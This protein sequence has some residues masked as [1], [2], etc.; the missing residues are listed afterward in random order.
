MQ[1]NGNGSIFNYVPDEVNDF[2]GVFHAQRR[3]YVF[4]SHVRCYIRESV[5]IPGRNIISVKD[6]G[7]PVQEFELFMDGLVDA[8]QFV[9]KLLQRVAPGVGVVIMP[10][11]L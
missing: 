8:R 2:L 3:I 4:K 5:G 1:L 6:Q 7:F 10:E 9:Q 11:S